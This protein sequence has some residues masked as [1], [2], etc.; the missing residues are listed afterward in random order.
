MD[1]QLIIETHS[2]YLIRRTQV[3][4]SE[5]NYKTEEDLLENNPFNVVYF[6]KE[7]QEYPF[8]NME[9]NT[10]GGFKRSFMPG[11]FD[12]AS[13]LD[14]E[15]IRKERELGNNIPMDANSLTK[16]LNG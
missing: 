5:E 14:M 11:F 15:I 13:K 3:I 16:L 2:E 1:S 10:A 6:D 4:V 9:Y 8:Y 7:S 12:E